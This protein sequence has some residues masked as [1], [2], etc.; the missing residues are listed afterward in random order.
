MVM[1]SQKYWKIT[2]SL[3]KL[4]SIIALENVCFAIHIETELINIDSFYH[5]NLLNAM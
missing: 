3:S 4:R 5:E 1:F 2:R